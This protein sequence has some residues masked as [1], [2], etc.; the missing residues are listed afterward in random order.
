[1]VQRHWASSEDTEMFQTDRGIMVA[2]PV[3]TLKPLEFL[4]AASELFG[5]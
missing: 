2:Q 4:F 1:M 3:C 5:I